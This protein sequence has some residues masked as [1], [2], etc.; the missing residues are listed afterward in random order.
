MY[1]Q[2]AASNSGAAV[3]CLL[4]VDAVAVSTK[5]QGNAPQTGQTDQRINNAADDRILSAKDPSHQVEFEYANQAP[6]Q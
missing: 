3:F 5:Q 2:A 4:C 1:K 6:V